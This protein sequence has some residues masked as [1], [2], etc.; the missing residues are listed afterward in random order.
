MQQAGHIPPP[1]H[2][3]PLCGYRFL[4]G[5][6]HC[7]GCPMVKGC[8]TTRCPR[9]SYEFLDRSV[10]VD[11]FRKLGRGVASLLSRIRGGQERER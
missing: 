2:H 8:G 6:E 4:R 11:A 7:G 9:C 10:T 1:T 3:C 5:A